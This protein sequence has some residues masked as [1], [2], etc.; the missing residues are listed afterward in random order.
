M[1]LTDRLA[2]LGVLFIACYL[3]VL[4]WHGPSRS[5]EVF[6]FFSWSLFSEVPDAVEVD[7]SV[8]F[9][10][11]NGVTL[12]EPVF[13]EESKAFLRTASAPQAY[14][15]IQQLGRAHDKNQDRRA[16]ESQDLL[17]SQ[18]LASLTSADYEVVRRE[19]DI[20]ERLECDCYSNVVVL[21]EA[22]LGS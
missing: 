11:V 17:D 19:F 12:D 5:P 9:I 4:L 8:R 6:P 1:K 21:S 14:Q 16:A 22:S 10:S 20:L 15:V 13:F 3:G 7:Y 18:W 2:A